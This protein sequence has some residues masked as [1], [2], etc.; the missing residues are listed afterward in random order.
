[1]G[2]NT[3]RNIGLPMLIVVLMSICLFS[4][5][6]IAYS[7][8]RHSYEQSLSMVER[9]K[10]YYGACNE[11]EELL[12][13]L[14]DM[15]PEGATY[16]F[17]FGTA[18]DELLVSVVPAEGGRGFEITEWVIADTASWEAPTSAGGSGPQGP[19][20]PGEGGGGSQGPSAPSGGPQAPSGGPQAPSGGPQAP[21]E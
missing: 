9:T 14:S 10:N 19:S 5:S 2:D 18:M 6:G 17:P 20:A 1:M 4:F 13:T 7:T 3:P 21:A 11:A 8:A 12:S 16:N 15:P